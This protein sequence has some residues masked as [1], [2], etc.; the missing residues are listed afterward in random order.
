MSRR[1]RPATAAKAP[2]GRQAAS[3]KP[4]SASAPPFSARTW[5]AI[6]AVILVTFLVYIPS[7]QNGFT[8]WDDN[9]YVTTSRILAHPTFHAILT[10]PITGNYHPLTIYSYVLNYKWFGLKPAGYHGINLLLHLANTALVFLF[11]WRLSRGRFWT[12]SMTSLLFGIH[13]MHVESVAWIAERKDVLYAFFYLLG[14]LAYLRYLDRRRYIWLGAAAL[15]HALSAASKPA[16]AVFPLTLLAVDSFRRRKFGGSLL[17]EKIPFLVISLATGIFTLQAQR[18][19]GAIT[20]QWQPIKRVLFAAYGTFIYLVKLFV[21]IRLSA[22]YPTPN[23]T[24]ANLGVEYIAALVFVMAFIAAVLYFGR[25]SR[26]VLFGVAFFFINIV[27][28][29]Q[30][31]S[32]GQAVLAE[33]YTYIPYIGLFLALTWWLDQQVAAGSRGASVRRVIAACLIALVPFSLVQT[34]NR[35]HVWKDSETLWNDTIE[36][37]PQ[38]ARAWNF[39]GVTMTEQNRFDEAY[40]DFD[41]AVTLKPDYFEALNNRAAMKLR[42]NDTAGALTDLSE[43]IRLHPLY[44]DAY[45]NRSIAYGRMGENDRSIADSRRFIELDPA[46]PA[47]AGEYAAIADLEQQIGRHRE[48]VDDYGE[49]IRRAPGSAVYYLS[50]SHSWLALGDRGAALNDARMAQRLGLSV[51]PSYITSLGG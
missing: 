21:P 51:A 20:Y 42:R 28:V 32:V 46:D 1:R 38:S 29:L 2:S 30:L 40:T 50:R 14:L 25:R 17:L 43:A 44:R 49:A 33:R 4:A 5:L 11:V 8:N 48:A 37:S 22:L 15:L 34:W 6:A 39:K 3:G 47:N 31:V 13:P 9:H 24:Q 26:V 35:I 16:A 27:L 23:S 12:S 45:R 41:R 36:K 10:T 7:L 18:F 19:A